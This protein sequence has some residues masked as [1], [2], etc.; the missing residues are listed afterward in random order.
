MSEGVTVAHGRWACVTAGEYDRRR[1]RVV[2]NEAVVEA[3]ARETGHAADLV[4]AAIVGHE[5][6]HART[7]STTR[8]DDERRARE[9]AVEAAG[10][11]VVDA[12]DLVLRKNRHADRS[13]R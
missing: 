8:A 5:M 2:V 11:T 12:I 13:W 7:L 10:V 3:V 6:A 9:A 4:R 1:H